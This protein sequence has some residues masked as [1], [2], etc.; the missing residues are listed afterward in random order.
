MG[1]ETVHDLVKFL[2]PYPDKVKAAALWLREFVWD[3]YPES[4]ELIYVDALSVAIGFS[5]SDRAGDKFCSIAVHNNHVNFGLNKGSAIAD[6]NKILSGTG[7]YRFIRV[8]K[9]DDF[10]AGYIKKL[11][12]EAHHNS[13][14]GL[15]TI[16]QRL[17]GQTIIKSVSPAAKARLAGHQ[18]L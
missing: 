16:K 9:V 2:L 6:P 13:V 1:K 18:N 11:L 10:P 3:L 5:P 7:I 8:T 4:N 17:K 15:K 14:S 12:A